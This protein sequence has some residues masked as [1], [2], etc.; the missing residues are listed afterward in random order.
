MGRGIKHFIFWG[1]SSLVFRVALEDSLEASG[2]P[3][4]LIETLDIEAVKK[5]S[6]HEHAAAFY[7]PGGHDSVYA[8]ELLGA[9]NESIQSYVRGGGSFV[10]ICG[11][12]YY[13][14]KSFVFVHQDGTPSIKQRKLDLFWGSSHGPVKLKGDTINSIGTAAIAYKPTGSRVKFIHLPFHMGQHFENVEAAKFKTLARF[15]HNGRPA[16]IKGSYGDGHVLLCAPHP[17]M[18]LEAF[19]KML[20]T[21]PETNQLPGLYARM[22]KYE[23]PRLEFFRMLLSTV[24]PSQ[25]ERKSARVLSIQPSLSPDLLVKKTRQLPVQT[26]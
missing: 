8:E 25:N 6:W 24:I 18:N 4:S 3:K 19:K 12:A 2:I 23:M 16:I 17:E 22:A 10:G 13:A 11:G 5:R 20:D 14:S 15:V 21:H 7:M 9:G 1:K 26:L